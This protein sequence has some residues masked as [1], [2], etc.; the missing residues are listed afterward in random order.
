MY[1]RRRFPGLRRGHIP[2]LR[3]DRPGSSLSWLRH[4]CMHARQRSVCVCV[5]VCSLFSTYL[6]TYMYPSSCCA[7]NSLKSG[8]LPRYSFTFH[9]KPTPQKRQQISL[10]FP[11]RETTRKGG[12]SGHQS[13]PGPDSRRV[14]GSFVPK[15]RIVCPATSVLYQPPRGELE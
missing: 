1:I 4:A 3:N 14:R 9:P 11:Y 6:P 7:L 13:P 2:I 12:Y 10:N 15:S 5:C 8:Y